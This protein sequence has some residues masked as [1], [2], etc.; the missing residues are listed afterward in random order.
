LSPIPHLFYNADLL[1]I[2][3]EEDLITGYIDDISIMVSGKVGEN[4]AR[5]AKIHK[6]AEEAQ[7]HASIF[8]LDKYELLHFQPKSRRQSSRQQ[9]SSRQDEE[10]L[11]LELASSRTQSIVPATAARYLGVMLDPELNG[12]AHLKHIAEST[13]KSVNALAAISGSTWGLPMPKMR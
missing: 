7:R 5:L 11:H 4:N 12:K 9:D 3:G 13:E 6:K 10:T 2:G 1:E 8:V